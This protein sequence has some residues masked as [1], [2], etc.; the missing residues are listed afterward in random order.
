MSSL[1]KLSAVSAT[2]PSGGKNLLHN[3]SLAINY[4][5]L[6]GI[7]GRSG[8]GKSTLL[9][10]LNRLQATSE[11]SITYDE[12]PLESY[13][14][15]ALRRQI[16]MVPQE[17][18]LLGM[19]V[20]ECL[21]YPLELQKMSSAECQRRLWQACEFWQ[22][23][24]DWLDRNELQLSLGQRQLVTLARGVI[25]NPRILL[26]DEP[27]SALDPTTANGVVAQLKA[28]N[29]D[30]GTTMVMVNHSPN[31]LEDFA[32]RIIHLEGG[33]LVGEKTVP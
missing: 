23:P 1:L 25:L 10:L 2:D 22:I 9:R 19:T 3:I 14:I 17:P 27:T 11:G 33:K 8:A 16:V 30:Y 28:W 21:T 20:A 15:P 26:L 13:G 24:S 12:K 31:Y 18:K 7:A 5:E 4:G 29:H 6:L 32:Q